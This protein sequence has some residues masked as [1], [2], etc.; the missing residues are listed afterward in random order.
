MIKNK[1]WVLYI[2]ILVIMAVFPFFTFKKDIK[3]FNVSWVLDGNKCNVYFKVYNPAQKPLT[4]LIT[5]YVYSQAANLSPA[6]RAGMFTLVGSKQIEIQID[7]LS[8][9]VIQET[10]KV[11]TPGIVKVDVMANQIIPSTLK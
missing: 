4:S 1:R 9:K 2:V 7:A 11:L 6:A 5:I 3:I 8:L 10:V